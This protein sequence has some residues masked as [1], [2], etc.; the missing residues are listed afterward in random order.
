MV[1]G[2][3]HQQSETSLL[4]HNYCRKESAGVS[5]QVDLKNTSHELPRQS[6]GDFSSLCERKLIKSH[7]EPAWIKYK[8]ESL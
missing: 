7:Q 6:R 8:E 5:S 3:E 4:F 1:R 2:K